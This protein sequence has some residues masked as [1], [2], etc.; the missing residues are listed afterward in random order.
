MPACDTGQF[1]SVTLKCIPNGTCANDG[2]CKTGGTVCDLATGA[3]VPGGCASQ[4]LEVTPVP[5]NLLIALDRSCSMNQPPDGVMGGATKW[6]IASTAINGLTTKLKGK[7]RFGITMFPERFTAKANDC[8]QVAPIPVPVG[9]NNEAAV[10]A[11][12][13]DPS[14]APANPCVTN[15]DTGFEQAASDPGLQDAKRGDYVVLMTDGAQSASCGG[16]AANAGT[17][18][19]ITKLAAGGVHTFVIGFGG[20]VD[21]TALTSFAQAGLEKNPNAPPDYYD[22]SDQASL[23]AAFKLIASKTLGCVFELKKAPEDPN[24]VYAFFDGMSVPR[25]PTHADGWDYDAAT[26]E[27][28]FYGMACGKLEEGKINKLDVVYGCNA[29]PPK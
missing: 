19:A 1:C 12:L 8:L 5:P 11:L 13:V 15:I 18:D 27:V 14:Y 17:V 23:D 29:P 24:Q 4:Q 20:A 28:T 10:Q 7:I 2:D 25:D 22:A 9:P 6:E 16:K 21:A 3:C 26:N